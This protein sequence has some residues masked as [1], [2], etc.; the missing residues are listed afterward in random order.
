MTFT[1]HRTYGVKRIGTLYIRRSPALR[2][3]VRIHCC[4][5]ERGLRSGTLSAQQIVGIGKAFRIIRIE[6]NAE[7]PGIL[8]LQRRFYAGH[9][10]ISRAYL[11]GDLAQ[12]VPHN[13]NFC[14][15]LING[16]SLMM[17]M[18]Q[19]SSY[20]VRALER[21]HE[22]AKGVIRFTIGRFTTEHEID[23]PISEVKSK[24]LELREQPPCSTTN[25]Q[26][27]RVE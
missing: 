15:D 27:L 2:L 18:N 12:R 13:L 3:G 21:S 9:E 19:E 1:A 7:L 11:S 8:A 26:E 17:A 16:G 23:F 4:G 22:L 20:V 14:F 6:M 25:S 10:S 5:H 24:V